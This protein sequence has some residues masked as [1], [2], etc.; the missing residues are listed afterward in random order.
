MKKLTATFSL[1]EDVLD[2]SDVPD[3]DHNGWGH[4]H[5]TVFATP[6]GMVFKSHCNKPKFIRAQLSLNVVAV[7]VIDT[8]ADA[9]ANNSTDYTAATAATFA[10]DYSFP[11][12]ATF[13]TFDT[14]ASFA[15]FAT[16][17][18]FVTFSTF[19]TFASFANGDHDV[20]S[21]LQLT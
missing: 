14:F 8:D 1:F 12:F 6:T 2:H 16:F 19:D 10:S 7:S 4:I 18:T 17:A 5:S 20:W 21:H 9:D 11:A 13:T 15:Y 3:S